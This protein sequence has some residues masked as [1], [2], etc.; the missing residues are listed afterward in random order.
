VTSFAGSVARVSVLL[1]VRHPLAYLA[2]GPARALGEELALAFDWLPLAVPPLKPPS[3]PA[4]NDDRGVRHRRYRAQAI[5]R[6]IEIYGAAQGL[7]LRD[8]Y[9]EGDAQAAN[10]AWLWV[11]ARHRPLLPDFL[12]ELFRAHWARELD[13]ADPEAVARLVERLAADSDD[14]RAWSEGEGRIAAEALASEL[15]DFGLFQVP[16]FVVDD[17]VFYGRQHQPMI[18]WILG[19]RVGVPPC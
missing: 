13:P 16:A 1:D 4:S 9:R 3:E 19:G 7:V 17:E 14:L 15:R 12:A 18:R 11:R 2:L 10:L 5:A 6:E 8:T